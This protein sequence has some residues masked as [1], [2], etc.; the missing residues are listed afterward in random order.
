MDLEGEQENKK[1]IAF[2]SEGEREKKK[3]A[4]RRQESL[5]FMRIEQRT[6]IYTADKN[7]ISAADVNR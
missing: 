2:T 4:M 6:D 1:I 5:C 7:L 3:K